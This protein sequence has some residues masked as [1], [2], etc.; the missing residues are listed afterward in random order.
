MPEGKD[1]GFDNP[2]DVKLRDKVR[3]GKNPEFVGA[4]LLKF[5][6]N[7][8]LQSVGFTEIEA[9]E[10]YNSLSA[11]GYYNLKAGTKVRV[12]L[13][14]FVSRHALGVNYFDAGEVE[15]PSDVEVGKSHNMFGESGKGV[16]LH[17]NLDSEEL[18]RLVKDT[19]EIDE[20]LERYHADDSGN[21]AKNTIAEVREII[22]MLR[23]DRREDE[24]AIARENSRL[25]QEFVSKNPA[26]LKYLKD[27][28]V[29]LEDAA[30]ITFVAKLA[31]NTMISENPQS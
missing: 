3:S 18:R 1:G 8:P 12:G 17:F 19:R 5:D 27:N 20:E 9:P 23:K 30:E 28:N 10:V 29:P 22:G 13:G 31:T 14:F 4:S 21:K 24:S 15:M 25:A 26:L 7:K 16:F 6:P 11:N 2:I